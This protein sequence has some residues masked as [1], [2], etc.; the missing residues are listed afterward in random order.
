MQVL[1]SAERNCGEWIALFLFS[2]LNLGQV[3]GRADRNIIFSFFLSSFTFF[4]L[5]HPFFFHFLFRILVLFRIFR[6]RSLALPYLSSPL[7]SLTLFGNAEHFNFYPYVQLSMLD[8]NCHSKCTM[9][10]KCVC[11]Q[12]THL[13]R[14]S[15][16]IDTY[17]SSTL[18][19]KAVIKLCVHAGTL[20]RCRFVFFFGRWFFGGTM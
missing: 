10:V 16:L 3:L 14:F 7:L 5:F 11:G 6:G 4:T 19:S 2:G 12:S 13:N 20:E 8:I 17:R 15:F 1:G 18:M 9:S